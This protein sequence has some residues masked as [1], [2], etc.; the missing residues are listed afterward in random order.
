MARRRAYTRKPLRRYRRKPSTRR[1]YSKKRST[2]TRRRSGMSNRR[3]LNVSSKKKRDTMTTYSSPGDLSTPVQGPLLLYAD[4]IAANYGCFVIPWVATARDVE[5]PRQGDEHLR[6]SSTCYMGVYVSSTCYMRGLREQLRIYTSSDVPWEWRRICFT[7]KG[8]AIIGPDATP[9]WFEN[10]AG[11]QRL[12]RPLTS[13]ASTSADLATA[14]RLI[15]HLF[16]GSYGT[17]F[18]DLFTAKAESRMLTVKYDKVTIIRS[19]NAR[20][21]LSVKKLWHPMNAN[22]SYDDQEHGSDVVSEYASTEGKPG[23]GDYYVVDLFKPHPSGGNADRLTFG[24]QA[25]LYWHER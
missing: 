13:S 7:F 15:N 8:S 12:V 14:D 19:G 22:L 11:W 5:E 9:F 23:M 10:S 3:I 4:G 17:D 1:S 18:H 6:T 24:S 21:T 2:Y 25:T 20:G 16:E